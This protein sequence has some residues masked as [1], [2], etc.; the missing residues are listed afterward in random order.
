MESAPAATKNPLN[1]LVNRLIRRKPVSI[2]YEEDYTMKNKM[3]ID[4]KEII[5]QKGDTIIIP[6][7]TVQSCSNLSRK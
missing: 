5:M 1:V 3:H 2:S 6:L 7:K 4:K